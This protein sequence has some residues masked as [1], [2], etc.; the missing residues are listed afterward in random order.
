MLSNNK[1]LCFRTRYGIVI[2]FSLF[3]VSQSLAQHQETHIK[4][5][6]TG[7]AIQEIP[8]LNGNKIRIQLEKPKSDG[9]FPVLIGVEGDYVETDDPFLHEFG[10]SFDDI[11]GRNIRGC[12]MSE[13]WEVLQALKTEPFPD[14][15]YNHPSEYVANAVDLFFNSDRTNR[16][17]EM[18]N[19]SIFQLLQELRAR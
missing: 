10:H 8:S 11:V 19:P 1:R 9:P 5:S 6:E 17:L 3:L 18:N 16:H 12:P 2:A 4:F 7:S 15:Y 14:W 13:W